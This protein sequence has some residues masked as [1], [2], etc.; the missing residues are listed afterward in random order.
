MTT[1]TAKKKSSKKSKSPVVFFRVSPE[2]YETMRKASEASGSKNLSSFARFAVLFWVES[3]RFKGHSPDDAI[4][5]LR[6]K[7]MDFEAEFRQ[8]VGNCAKCEMRN[9]TESLI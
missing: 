9:D 4:H 5:S 7:F 8:F 2:Q 1:T 6:A 3:H